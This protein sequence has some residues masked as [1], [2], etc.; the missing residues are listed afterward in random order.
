MAGSHPMQ[1]APVPELLETP[2][3]D[4]MK[5]G[6]TPASASG[7]VAASMES[8]PAHR[9]PDGALADPFE[10]DAGLSDGDA[11]KPD[12]AGGADGEGAA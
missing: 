7:A 3:V 12:Q 6:P 1:A 2:P 11:E 8:V 10:A 5:S 9:E 4:A